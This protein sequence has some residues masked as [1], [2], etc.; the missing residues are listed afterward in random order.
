VQ[1]RAQPFRRSRPL[2]RLA[3]VTAAEQPG[4]EMSYT[5]WTQ[6]F[7]EHARLR[8]RIV[9]RWPGGGRLAPALVRSV[10]RFQTGEDGDGA[11]LIRKSA[12]AGDPTYLAAVRLFIAEEQNHAR[13]LREV[14][15]HAGEPTIGRHWSDTA[16][17]AVRRALGLR[18]ELMTLMVAEVISL[19]YYRALRDGV[20]D[21]VVA[22]VAGR[23]LADEERHVPFHTDRLR[24]GFAR[25]PR[26]VRLGVAAAWWVLMAGALAVV[27][28]DHGAALGVLGV[29]RRRFVA[30]TCH[31]FGPVVLDA[32]SLPAGRRSAVRMAPS[33]LS[34]CRP[35]GRAASPGRG[36]PGGA[37]PATR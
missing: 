32:A 20:A 14:L 11:N 30:D 35:A 33:R 9:E 37:G 29:G 25:L 15:R 18:L 24:D 4:D 23:I 26:P 8:A 28:V 27:A 13:L 2:G 36:V 10:Q 19:R 1:I 21:P 22:E 5:R 17:V 16:F 34:A 3:I 6:H 31:L 7:E 12:Q